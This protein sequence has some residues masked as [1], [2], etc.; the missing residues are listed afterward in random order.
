MHSTVFLSPNNS[1]YDEFS[2]TQQACSS[3][4][5]RLE[6]H[7]MKERKVRFWVPA[8]GFSGCLSGWQA[9]AL[10]LYS[11]CICSAF[12]QKNIFI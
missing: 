10:I 8:F 1:L 11:F 7:I 6:A 4:L 9:K 5:I 3:D 12:K 2:K